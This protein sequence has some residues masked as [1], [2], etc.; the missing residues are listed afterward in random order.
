MFGDVVSKAHK[1]GLI[2]SLGAAVR[3]WMICYYCQ[4]INFQESADRSKEFADEFSTNLHE[5]IGR[6]TVRDDQ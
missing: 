1:N 4:M 6:D 5:C 2:K 3:L